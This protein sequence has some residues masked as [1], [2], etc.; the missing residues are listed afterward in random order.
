MVVTS[1]LVDFR[2]FLLKNYQLLS[3]DNADETQIEFWIQSNWEILVEGRI[4]LERGV[5]LPAVILPPFANGIR[6]SDWQDEDDDN[7]SR[8]RFRK[9]EVTHLLM[10]NE[11]YYR[12]SSFGTK[13]NFGDVY[14]ITPPFNFMECISKYGQTAHFK[15]DESEN[16]INS[17]NMTI[18]L[19]PIGTLPFYDPS[20]K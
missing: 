20:L 19:T 3:I 6:S 10:V 17:T 1:I 16:A 5:H 18:T 14:Q 7:S 11:D 2:N 4:L 15:F 9:R 13:I 12:F 8:I